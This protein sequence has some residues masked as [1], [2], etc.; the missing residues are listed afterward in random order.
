MADEER[1]LSSLRSL[2]LLNLWSDGDHSRIPAW[3]KRFEQLFPDHRTVIVQ[4]AKHFP[5]EDNPDGLVT[6]IRDWWENDLDG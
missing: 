5:Q 4:G 1:G 3:S 6:A 2:P